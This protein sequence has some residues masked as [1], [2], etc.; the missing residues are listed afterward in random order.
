MSG[1]VAQVL[2]MRIADYQVG[3]LPLH[4]RSSHGKEGWKLPIKHLSCTQH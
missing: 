2:G 3:C 4:M 1:R